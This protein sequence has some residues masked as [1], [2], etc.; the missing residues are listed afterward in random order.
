MIVHIYHKFVIIIITVYYYNYYSAV[1]VYVLCLS[2]LKKYAPPPFCWSSIGLLCF[3][4]LLLLLR[5]PVGW[6]FDFNTYT[7]L[8]NEI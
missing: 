5:L 8:H 2:I 1:S 7:T 6:A 3:S 4:V